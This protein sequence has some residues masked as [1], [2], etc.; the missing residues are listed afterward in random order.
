M[1]PAADASL[2]VSPFFNWKPRL[3]PCLPASGHI[4]HAMEAFLFQNARADTRAIA[5]VAID[6]GWFFFVELAGLFAQ[7][8]N[9]DAMRAGH[10]ALLPLGRRAHVHDLQ[11]PAGVFDFMHCYLSDLL[12]RQPGVVPRF[13]PA[14]EI[15][16]E[17]RVAGADEELEYL[18]Q[19]VIT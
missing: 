15:A 10:V 13:H 1:R 18:I 8:G 9:K 19:F 17:F 12:Q 2:A 11:S 7:I 3:L 14:D 5:T 6:G 16:H 4:A